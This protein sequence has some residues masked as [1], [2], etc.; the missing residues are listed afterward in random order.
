MPHSDDAYHKAGEEGV[1]SQ[2]SSSGRFF[3]VGAA[4]IGG[5]CLGVIVGAAVIP[6]LQSNNAAAS[7]ELVGMPTS[8]RSSSMLGRG[9]VPPALA[10]LPGSTQWKELAIASIEAANRCDQGG[11]ST[12]AVSRMNSIIADMPQKDQ[13]FIAMATRKVQRKAQNLKGAAPY[14]LT[15]GMVA[16]VEGLFDPWKLSAQATE[17]E[18]LFFREAELK[19]GRV[20][21]L[22]SLGF[23]A[24]KFHPFF[25]QWDGPAIQAPVQTEVLAF[26]PVLFVVLGIP[27]I[28]SLKRIDYN[29]PSAGFTPQLKKGLEPGAIGWDPLGIKPT[30]PD[31]Y[32]VRKN[33]ELLHGRL[34]MIAAA[35]MIAQETLTQSKLGEGGVFNEVGLG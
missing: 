35:G 30:D 15:E 4:V 20:C 2:R 13:D 14:G 10:S 11:V 31:D 29:A 17:G 21:M 1:D 6:S 19:H 27:E 3:K 7:T 24:E 28:E 26:W 23:Y 12:K 22:A 8:L 32:M 9:L 18:L 5:L 33:Q 34:G 16:P 25:G